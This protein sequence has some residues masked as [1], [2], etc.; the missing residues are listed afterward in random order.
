[1]KC[2]HADPWHRVAILVGDGTGDG[3]EPMEADRDVGDLLIS[4]EIH[5]A[6]CDGCR[7]RVARALHNRHVG[8]GA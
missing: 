1:M 8:A 2:D 4:R 6:V 7:Q 3:G 5:R